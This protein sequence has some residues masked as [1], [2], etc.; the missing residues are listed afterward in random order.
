MIF[1]NKELTMMDEVFDMALSVAKEKNK[2]RAEQ[3]LTT[4]HKWVCERNPDKDSE[5]CLRITKSNLGYMAGYHNVSVAQL[6]ED[7][8]G[9]IHPIFGC[10]E[11]RRQLTPEQIFNMGKEMAKSQLS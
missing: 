6:I 4:Y 10:A 8:Y 11:L 5:E 2:E 7:A 9:A 1:D 3:F